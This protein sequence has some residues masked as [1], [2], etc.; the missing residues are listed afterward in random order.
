MFNA[1]NLEKIY[2][3]CIFRINQRGH[4]TTSCFCNP[5]Q[6]KKKSSQLQFW[7]KSLLNNK[8]VKDG[9]TVSW[10]L[11]D[12]FRKSVYNIH[13]LKNT[14]TTRKKVYGLRVILDWYSALKYRK[15]SKYKYYQSKNLPLI[16]TEAHLTPQNWSCLLDLHPARLE[17]ISWSRDQC[18]CNW[19]TMT[20]YKEEASDQRCHNEGMECLFLGGNQK[21][22]KTSMPTVQGDP[23]TSAV[24]TSKWTDL[25]S[26]VLSKR[27]LSRSQ[28][29][30]IM[31]T[32]GHRAAWWDLLGSH[33]NRS[34][35]VALCGLELV[36]S[37]RVKA[38]RQK[39]VALSHL[40]S[41]EMN[42]WQKETE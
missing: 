4:R 31:F 22:T 13:S 39:S 28:R 15:C 36:Q 26:Q 9:C 40:S 33:W 8:Q 34:R 7:F 30:T 23:N 6:E 42:H 21:N 3:V 27:R 5:V 11:Y 17:T 24:K 29:F 19:L 37:Q 25:H 12:L 38:S 2:I 10:Q 16:Q 35:T 1:T 14:K 20:F 41:V 18:V 32:L